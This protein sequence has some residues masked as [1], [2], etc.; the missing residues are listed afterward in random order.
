MEL[1]DEFLTFLLEHSSDPRI[2]ISKKI[3]YG[4][5]YYLI[6]LDIDDDPKDSKNLPSRGYRISD[7][8]EFHIDNRNCCIEI[9]SDSGTKNI[10][11]EDKDL[12]EKWSTVAEEYINRDL[13]EKTKFTIEKALNECHNKSLLRD[14]KMKKIF[15]SNE[16]LQPRRT[17]K[18]K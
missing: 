15:N 14:Y 5:K 11:I 7:S 10:I 8:L 6:E 3:K 4:F 16:P 13:T 17:R 18:N 9:I 1:L 12:V 2:S